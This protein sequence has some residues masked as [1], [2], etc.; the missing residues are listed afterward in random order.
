MKKTKNKLLFAYTIYS[1][2]IVI[3]V[4]GYFLIE[5]RTLVLGSGDA[6]Q[7][8][9]LVLY[10]FNSIMR[11]FI[12]TGDWGR[13]NFN[14]SIGIGDSSLAQ[15]GY[16]IMGDPF[17][18]LS[19]LFPMKYLAYGY[20]L[21]L[22]LRMYC[23]GLAFLHF[24]MWRKKVEYAL[25]GALVYEFSSWVIMASLMHPFFT[26][27]AILF[28]ILLV[29]IEKNML[30]ESNAYLIIVSTIT[31][32]FNFYFA[33][34]LFV[35]GVIWAGIYWFYRYK[36][37]DMVFIKNT[38][39]ALTRGILCVG[40][41]MILAAP[42]MLPTLIAFKNISRIGVETTNYVYEEAYYHTLL[43]SFF[44]YKG[45]FWA[46][47]GVSSFGIIALCIILTVWK[48]YIMEILYFSILVLILCIPKL[49]S[50]MNGFSYPTNR[51]TFAFAFIMSY[52]ISLSIEE[53]HRITRKQIISAVMMAIIFG[54]G[55]LFDSLSLRYWIVAFLILIIITG[56]CWKTGGKAV[57]H[58]LSLLIVI[59]SV[60][61]VWGILYGG[62]SWSKSF[63]T[64]RNLISNYENNYSELPGLSDALKYIEET[65]KGFYRVS[66]SKQKNIS[67]LPLF[68]N[69][70]GTSSYLSL[71]NGNLSEFSYDLGNLE[72]STSNPNGS[73]NGRCKILNILGVK[74]YIAKNDEHNIPYG[75]EQYKIIDGV[76][77]WK[78]KL[79]D[80]GIVAFYS[81]QYNIDSFEQQDGIGR[82]DML[83]SGVTK[84]DNNGIEYKGNEQELSYTISKKSD[85]K[86]ENNQIIVKNPDEKLILELSSPITNVELFLKLKTIKQKD[87]R[88]G[89]N[90]YASKGDSYIS[91]TIPSRQSQ[92]YYKFDELLFNLGYCSEKTSQI[93]VSFSTPGVYELSGIELYKGEVESMKQQLQSLY[94]PIQKVKI[95]NGKIDIQCKNEKEGIIQI[96]T[97]YSKGWKAVVNG[98]RTN[99]FEVNNGLMGVEVPAG[100]VE[101]E[102]EYFTPGFRMGVCIQM[103]GLIIFVSMKKKR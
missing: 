102:L 47:I 29:A 92:Y 71:V 25:V 66:I 19:L 50:V 15:Y 21:L 1:L 55:L 101:I 68:L 2:L 51:W 49:G 100:Q 78:N 73:F 62:A 6:F 44:T 36:K 83:L 56:W 46:Y 79:V 42:I 76:T 93:A 4:F 91:K 89:F 52:I 30:C 54:V 81:K 86:L 8:H 7:Q 24:M 11:E 103:I 38:F 28:P 98:E 70:N 72:Y 59:N 84:K 9:Y 85:L 63:Y 13:L 67:N 57:Y 37:I 39:K 32:C 61:S 87:E 31:F 45:E 33:Y 80:N 74:Y 64:R 96:A 12:R 88:L 35:M 23:T 22:I 3:V 65:D 58:V 14:W 10:D 99:T 18:Y 16:Y 53:L 60:M 95:D 40:C 94:N 48:R 90:I 34:K 41:G 5:K 26:N 43:E 97:G 17:A 20:S 27:A 75:F 77:I 82:E 69:Y